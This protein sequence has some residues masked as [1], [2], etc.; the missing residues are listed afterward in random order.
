VADFFKE[1]EGRLEAIRLKRTD[2]AM[3]Q[4]D[5]STKSAHESAL[6]L[7]V[8][9]ATVYMVMGLNAEVEAAINKLFQKAIIYAEARAMSLAIDNA[10]QAK[11]KI[12]LRES[13]S[14]LRKRLASEKKADEQFIKALSGLD[15]VHISVGKGRPRTWTKESLEKAVR[16]ASL[17]VRKEK[18]RTPT[19]NDMARDLNKRNPD[20]V[21]L[22]GKALGQMLKR[23]KVNWKSIKNPHN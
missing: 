17:Q 6:S 8:Q 12:D 11:G 23:Y 4:F 10:E 1:F 9:Y 14:T 13:I 3:F 21:R 5:V 20:R 19:L 18:Y 15:N 16:K 7:L 2:G 22:T